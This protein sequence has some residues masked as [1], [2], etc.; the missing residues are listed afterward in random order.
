VLGK[1]IK[2]GQKT[3]LLFFGKTFDRTFQPRSNKVLFP[4]IVLDFH[5]FFASKGFKGKTLENIQGK[6]SE[7]LF[8]G[9]IDNIFF[10]LVFQKTLESTVRTCTSMKSISDTHVRVYN[11]TRN[12]TNLSVA[13]AS[14]VV[15]LLSQFNFNYLRC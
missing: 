4:K 2:K 7:N 11:F 9:L 5:Q 3:N 1:P 14:S 13:V 6:S 12:N 8:D 15:L 10:K